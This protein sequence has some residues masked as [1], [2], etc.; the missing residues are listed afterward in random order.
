MQQAKDQTQDFKSEWTNQP[1]QVC[2]PGFP[3]WETWDLDTRN[4]NIWVD[5][6]KELWQVPVEEQQRRLLGF[7]NKAMLP[8]VENYAPF[9]IQ[10]LAC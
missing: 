8:S 9:E 7:W 2:E 10:L 1:R 5:A 3:G 4:N 6:L